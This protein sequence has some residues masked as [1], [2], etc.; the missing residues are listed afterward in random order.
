MTSRLP[1]PLEERDAAI[2]NV[3]SAN[4]DQDSGL[5]DQLR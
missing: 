3:S 2:Y 4:Y 5:M 1:Q